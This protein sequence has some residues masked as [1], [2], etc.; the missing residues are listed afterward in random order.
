MKLKLKRNLTINSVNN[1]KDSVVEVED[2][3]AKSILSRQ[4]AT[5]IKEPKKT[6]PS[7]VEAKQVEEPKK[8]EE[9]VETA[10]KPKTETK[11]VTKAPAKKTDTAKKAPAKKA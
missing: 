1:L 6:T 11:K 9:V 7:V 4:W 10:P 2:K 3:D 5:E 8:K